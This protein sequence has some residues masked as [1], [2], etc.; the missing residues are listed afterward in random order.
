MWKTAAQSTYVKYEMV[1]QCF[2]LV[3]K[4]VP[5]KIFYYNQF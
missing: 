3:F 1:L 5:K 2:I 4:K